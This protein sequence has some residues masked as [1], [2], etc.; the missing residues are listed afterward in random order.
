MTFCD[1]VG[2]WPT[3]DSEVGEHKQQTKV[4]EVWYMFKNDLS[5]VPEVNIIVSIDF[6]LQKSNSSTFIV[7]VTNLPR[8]GDQLTPVPGQVGHFDW[9]F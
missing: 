3:T 1:E 2:C 9:D 8:Y 6:L 5:W 4:K 7:K